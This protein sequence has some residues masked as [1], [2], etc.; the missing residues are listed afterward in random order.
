MHLALQGSNENM[1][2]VARYFEKTPQNTEK[3]INLFFKAD[4][5]AKAID[6]CFSTK[7]FGM[8]GDLV[9]GLDKDVDPSVI[10]KCAVYFE[11]NQQYDKSAILLIK[12]QQISK[13]KISIVYLS[14]IFIGFRIVH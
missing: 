10:Q 1:L 13:V 7:Q 4:H 12:G 5:V 9:N 2:E 8:L 14:F 6:L 11:E 3:S